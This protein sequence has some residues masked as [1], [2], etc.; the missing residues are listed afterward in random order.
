MK[1][2]QSFG[3]PVYI[4]VHGESQHSTKAEIKSWTQQT[5]A[6]CRVIGGI[7]SSTE[8]IVS[9]STIIFRSDYLLKH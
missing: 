2:K 6:G 1:I 8:I 9:N 3:R 4:C 7:K 5:E